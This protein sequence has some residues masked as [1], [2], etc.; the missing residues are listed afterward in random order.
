M[1]S[2]HFHDLA[3]ALRERLLVIAD[4]DA[5]A[6]D[7]TS[8]MQRLKSVSEKINTLQARLPAPRDPQIEHFLQRCSYD[9]ALASIEA[10][11]AKPH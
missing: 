3:A 5:Y 8:H 6:Q 11:L 1:E 4:R 7:A 9:K 2:S 10:K